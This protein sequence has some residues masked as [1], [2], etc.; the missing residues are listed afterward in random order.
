V[1][2]GETVP[3]TV[4]A[5]TTYQTES[6]TVTIAGGAGVSFA[7]IIIVNP[8]KWSL[9]RSESSQTDWTIVAQKKTSFPS[10]EEQMEAPE[11]VFRLAMT[12]LPTAPYETL[13]DFTCQVRSLFDVKQDSFVDSP[14]AA[15][16]IDGETS[17]QPQTTGYLLVTEDITRGIWA[18]STFGELV[19]NA[20]LTGDPVINP[21]SV[22]AVSRSGKQTKLSSNALTCSV[23]SASIQAASDCSGIILDGSESN[24]SP[25][26]TLSIQFGTH[27]T[28]VSF[29]VWHP[30]IPVQVH[31]DDGELNAID[32]LGTTTCTQKYQQTAIHV[33]ATFVS[34]TRNFTGDISELV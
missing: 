8:A 33:Q 14:V 23:D 20:V 4:S 9:E 7:D 1:H 16:F 24:G 13:V 3:L 26:A 27:S 34:G 22:F 2:R 30:I 29:V 19:N 11:D 15:T 10:S 28:A 18:H 5:H 21:V 17:T 31:V 12:V 25:S 6:F 32:G